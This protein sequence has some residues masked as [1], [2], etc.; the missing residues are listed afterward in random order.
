[1][2]NFFVDM[3]QHRKFRHYSSLVTIHARKFLLLWDQQISYLIWS[4]HSDS[5]F[6]VFM[7]YKDWLVAC[8]SNFISFHPFISEYYYFNMCIH[9]FKYGISEFSLGCKLR[10]YIIY[11]TVRYYKIFT[12]LYPI[13]AS[14]TEIQ[15]YLFAHITFRSF[16]HSEQVCWIQ[17]GV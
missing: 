16:D 6:N 7:L 8:A 3:A 13:I 17:F 4:D 10:H 2:P 5:H 12:I 14:I 11:Y 9:C 15:K 1:M